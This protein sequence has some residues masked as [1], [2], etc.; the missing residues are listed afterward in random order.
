M[1]WA[2]FR[3]RSC[4]CRKTD[5]HSSRSIICWLSALVV[6]K[7]CQA[8]HTLAHQE[9]PGHSMRVNT[10]QTSL[11][12]LRLRGPDEAELEKQ[13]VSRPLRHYA[14]HAGGCES[15]CVRVCFACVPNCVCVS[16]A[17]VPRCMR[18]C[19]IFQQVVMLNVF[20]I[21][22]NGLLRAYGDWVPA[23]KIP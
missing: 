19:G 8:V 7:L 14:H 21:A 17:C 2:T 20:S 5:L 4:V 1:V 11:M 15:G 10:C 18:V 3:P 13:R 23:G 16:A 9:L 22:V 6:S 12:T